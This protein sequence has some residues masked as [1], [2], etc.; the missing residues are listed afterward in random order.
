MPH[1][2]ERG[3][4]KVVTV[5]PVGSWL[6]ESVWAYSMV[7]CGSGRWVCRSEGHLESL[8]EVGLFA[9]PH[10]ALRAASNPCGGRQPLT[11]AGS[12]GPDT[13]GPLAVGRPGP[14]NGLV[15]STAPCPGHQRKLYPQAEAWRTDHP[16]SGTPQ[17]TE[18][19]AVF[20]LPGLLGPHSSTKSNSG[21]GN[22][23]QEWLES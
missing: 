15:P 12:K 6:G 20:P 2:E 5:D 8:I 10:P 16:A 7:G 23:G 14:Y 17:A 4:T 19:L 18:A 11:H 1:S 21:T 13:D 22:R 9:G 3:T